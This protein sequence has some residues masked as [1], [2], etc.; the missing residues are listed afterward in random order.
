MKNNNL[1]I[2]FCDDLSNSPNEI[3]REKFDKL[4][5]EASAKMV[6]R[7]RNSHPVIIH[8]DLS[9]TDDF[10]IDSFVITKCSVESEADES[11]ES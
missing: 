6:D 7:M 2:D 1:R 3:N 9:K 8:M 5:N 4:V 10:V 11:V